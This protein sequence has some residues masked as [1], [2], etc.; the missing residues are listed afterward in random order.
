MPDSLYPDRPLW[1]LCVRFT[2][3]TGFTDS[4]M[5]DYAVIL[6]VCIALVDSRLCSVL[7]YCM[8]ACFVAS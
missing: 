8:L 7:P 3:V 4:R 1:A 6:C 5:L 2:M